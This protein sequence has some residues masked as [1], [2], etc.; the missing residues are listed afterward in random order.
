MKQNQLTLLAL[1]GLFIVMIA[2][3]TMQSAQQENKIKTITNETP[4]NNTVQLEYGLIFPDIEAKNVAVINILDPVLNSQVSVA[5]SSEGIWQVISEDN[6]PSDQEYANS[7]AITLEMIPFS[8]RLEVS[9]R[10]QYETFGLNEQDALIVVSAIMRDESLHTFMVGNPVSTDST[11]RGF[12][13]IVDDKESVYIVPPEP[14]LYL[15]QYLQA[16][17]NT[18]KLDN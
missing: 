17:E 14:I 10:N 4:I 9:N 18:Q 3:L 13:T 5:Q 11:T 6:R 16:F 1:A 8:T 2:L 15:I 7:L 12:Y